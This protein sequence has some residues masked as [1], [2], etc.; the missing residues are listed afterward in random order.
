[1]ESLPSELKE[2]ICSHLD[3]GSLH[4]LLQVSKRQWATAE[5]WIYKHV[6]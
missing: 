3:R 4:S 2:N 1:M 6:R 5:P